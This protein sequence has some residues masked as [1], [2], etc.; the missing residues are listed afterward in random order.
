MILSL[1]CLGKLPIAHAGIISGAIGGS[2][3]GQM[4]SA[5]MKKEQRQ[6]M[7]GVD[8]GCVMKVKNVYIRPKIIS[9]MRIIYNLNR[10]AINDHDID[11]DFDSKDE[12][13]KEANRIMIAIN[14]GEC[15]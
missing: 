1:I 14:T 4:V 5:Q 10:L 6:Q 12:I 8:M 2:I 11:I 15:K 9:S 7:A 13:E 3:A